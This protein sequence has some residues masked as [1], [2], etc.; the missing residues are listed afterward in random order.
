MAS[1][2]SSGGPEIPQWVVT[3]AAAGISF[4]GG[5]VAA[6]VNRS[7]ALQRLIDSRLKTLIDGYESRI[8]DLMGEL[9]ELRIEVARLRAELASATGGRFMTAIFSPD[10]VEGDPDF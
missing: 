5:I 9:H 6:L 10:R 7:P 2:M 3:I 1:D 8:A 4:V